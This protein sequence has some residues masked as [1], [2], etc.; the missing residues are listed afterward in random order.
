[1]RTLAAT[2]LLVPLLALG[3]ARAKPE[4]PEGKARF[5]LIGKIETLDPPKASSE[6]ART[7]VANLYD[8]L[9]EYDHLKRPYELKPCLAAELPEISEDGRTHTI[10]LEPGIRYVDDPC[11]PGGKGRAVTA[12]DVV[13]CIKRMMDAHT[14]SPGQWMLERKITGLD[15]FVKASAKVTPNPNRSVYRERDGYPDV[16]GLR[17]L[18]DLTLR[19]HLLEP[20]PELP[21]LMALPWVSIYPPEAVKQYGTLLARRAVGTGPYKLT[22]FIGGR[23]LLLQWNPDYREER[24][25]KTGTGRDHREGMMKCAGRRLPLNALVEV[26]TYDGEGA[27]QAAWGAFKNGEADCAE[28]PRGDSLTAAVDVR[29]NR[30]LPWLAKRGVR[31]HRDPRLEVFYDAFNHE[32]PVLGRPA[33]EKARA[34]RRAICLATDDVYAMTRLYGHQ[35]ERVYGPVLP[36]MRG[37]DEAFSN[38]WLRQDDESREEAVALAKELLEEAGIPMAKG[39]PVLRMHI[40]SDKG[41]LLVFQIFQRQL[42]EVGIRVEAVPVTWPEMQAALNAK[43]AQMWTS[44]WYADYPDAQNFLQLFYGPNSPDPNFSNYRNDEFDDYY[45]EARLLPPGDDRDLAYRQ[46]QRI[47]ADDC[48][49][50]FKFRRIR[51]SASQPWISGYRHN[52]VVQKYFKYCHVDE[53]ARTKAIEGWK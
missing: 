7:C 8:Q 34:L 46:M 49:W 26:T 11:F 20:M 52:D 30:L 15:A 1:M 21:W 23:R 25:P 38:D 41:A 14:K 22:L 2:V 17:A 13:F 51:W 53:D 19:V 40:M 29:T 32:D 47:V 31:L 36:E 44:S 18:D 24:Y 33:G 10:R 28:I 48:I 9:Y 45:A 39:V 6:S 43:K 5:A 16:P 4:T 35:S 3:T 27:A 12:S 50:R 42:A 37:Y